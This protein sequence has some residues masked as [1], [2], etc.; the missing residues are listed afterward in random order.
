MWKRHITLV[1]VCQLYFTSALCAPHRCFY[2]R[3]FG[4]S[5]NK[6]WIW[7]DTFRDYT[8]ITCTYTGNSLPSLHSLFVSPNPKACLL[9]LEREEWR[10]REGERTID[11][12]NINQ[13]SLVQTRDPIHNP[14]MCPDQESNP[15]PLG[16][17]DDA[18][19]N[20]NLARACGILF[21]YSFSV[22]PYPSKRCQL[23]LIN[24]ML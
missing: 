2:L 13:P 23:G 16:L 5:Y 8:H 12:K 10:G 21:C 20:T 1:T 6:L 11:V 7:G 3:V 9:I 4:G 17:Q 15:W 14:G 19:T 22:L 18:P 24:Q